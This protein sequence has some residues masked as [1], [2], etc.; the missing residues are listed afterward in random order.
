MEVHQNI[1]NQTLVFAACVSMIGLHS[2]I[3]Q[4]FLTRKN[5]TLLEVNRLG[6][7]L[8]LSFAKS[9][10]SLAALVLGLRGA[11]GC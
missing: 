1:P 6:R 7:Q 3:A 9:S 8:L 4:F 5:A 10:F 11:K 2:L